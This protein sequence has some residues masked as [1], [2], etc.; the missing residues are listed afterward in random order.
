MTARDI[1]P[2]ARH[3][4]R[5]ALVQALY[6]WQMT[7]AEF[8]E[9]R[10]HFA[11]TDPDAERAPP[12]LGGGDMGRADFAFFLDC[13]RGV[14]CDASLL[15]GLFAPHL[16]RGVDRLDPVERAILRAGVYELK[17]RLE[18]PARVV[19][20][21]WVALAKTFGATESFRYVNGVLDRVARQLRGAELGH[22][23]GVAP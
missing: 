17:E 13:L 22:P 9:L 7:G 12:S 19:L 21:E 10:S 14:I 23:A 3:R 8:H 15:D 2:R 16:D 18:V 11:P 1:D 20:D 5:R 6:A 4:A